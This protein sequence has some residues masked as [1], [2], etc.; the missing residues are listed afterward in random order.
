MKN[1]RAARLKNAGK[2][3]LQILLLIFTYTSI[4]SQSM[5]EDRAVIKV[6]L[7]GRGQSMNVYTSQ[8]D[9][10]IWNSMSLEMQKQSFT[11]KSK[12]FG[13][14]SIT[15]TKEEQTFILT[16]IK[17]DK[18]YTWCDTLFPGLKAIDLDSLLPY[19]KAKKEMRRMNTDNAFSSRDTSLARKLNE[20]HD[21]VFTFSKPIYLRN[22]TLCLLHIKN[23]CNLS[24][25]D[26]DLSFYR[27]DKNGTWVWWLYV[28]AGAW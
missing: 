2:V 13:K 25:G 19:L 15:L 26:Q 9:A 8:I 3:F 14:R 1:K 27:K 4:Y 5:E 21:W 17:E 20:T 6:A 28:S 22:G 10:Y 7:G 16:E 24:G 18:D 12:R 11:G 23:R